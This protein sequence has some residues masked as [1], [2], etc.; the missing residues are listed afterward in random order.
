MYR[1]TYR[2]E[3][4]HDG[5]NERLRLVQSGLVASVEALDR[6]PEEGA[7]HHSSR[8]PVHVSR[9]GERMQDFV[10]KSG[11]NPIPQIPSS[12]T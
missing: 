3:G 11:E 10:G 7:V 8:S 2:S 12:R 6:R 1:R 4:P 9:S 5:A